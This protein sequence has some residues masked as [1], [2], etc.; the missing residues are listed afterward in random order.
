MN[1][2]Y[3]DMEHELSLMKT[4]LSQICEKLEF[5]SRELCFLEIGLTDKQISKVDRLFIEYNIKNEVPSIEQVTGEISKVLDMEFSDI[6]TK[7]LLV[8]YEKQ[9]LLPIATKI[10]EKLR[11]S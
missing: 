9:E 5:D 8:N 3:Q 6:I 10:L 7:R 4:V 11:N 1:R 2:K